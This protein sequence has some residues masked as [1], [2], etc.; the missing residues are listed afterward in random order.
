MKVNLKILQRNGHLIIC[1]MAFAF[2]LSPAQARQFHKHPE[3]TMMKNQEKGVKTISVLGSRP[4][5]CDGRCNFCGHCEAIQVP[6]VPIRKFHI[7]RGKRSHFYATPR[8]E[9]SRG[10]NISNYKP[11]RWKCKCGDSTLNP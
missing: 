10:D 8:T 11:I 4:P 2:L 3:A 6:I 9:Y 5:R 7:Q 1:L